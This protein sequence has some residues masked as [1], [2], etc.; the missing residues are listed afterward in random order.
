MVIPLMIK[1]WICI[2]SPQGRNCTVIGFDESSL[3]AYARGFLSGNAHNRHYFFISPDSLQP[4]CCSE[5]NKVSG[6][7]ILVFDLLIL[8]LTG[9]KFTPE[10]D[11]ETQR[12]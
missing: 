12:N 4:L 5:L 1:Q 2:S 3:I 8:E 6:I 9:M 11:H 7:E 10:N